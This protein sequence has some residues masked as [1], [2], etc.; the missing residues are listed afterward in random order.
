MS[1]S[2]P[3]NPRSMSLVGV[4]GDTMATFAQQFGAI[5]KPK[6]PLGPT[7]FT[8]APVAKLV[9][10]ASEIPVQV[11][12]E[13][14]QVLMWFSEDGSKIR[15]EISATAAEAKGDD[16]FMKWA[17]DI[18]GPG[19]SL[20]D[21]VTTHFNAFGTF[22]RALRPRGGAKPHIG[23]RGS[24]ANGGA[25]RRSGENQDCRRVGQEGGRGRRPR[26]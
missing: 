2:A 19:G 24:I 21:T 13:P 22:P 10:A 1:A 9:D 5:H 4:D 14:R 17:S 18:Y 12:T 23:R 26:S 25:A 20:A 6:L 7:K 16:K 8:G 3:A 15:F 11:T